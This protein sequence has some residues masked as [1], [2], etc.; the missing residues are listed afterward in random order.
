MACHDGMFPP[1]LAFGGTVYQ[2]DGTTP[3]ANVEVGVKDGANQYFVYST[4][5]GI[6]WAEGVASSINWDAADIRMRNAAGEIPK[7]PEM[8]RSAD[9]DLCHIRS[10][11]LALIVD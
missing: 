1:Q 6:Y 3:A 5:N 8:A 7:T 2:A 4:T 11:S 10:T 9:C